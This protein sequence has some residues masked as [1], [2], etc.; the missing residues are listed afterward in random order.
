[1][2]RVGPAWGEWQE[3][4]WRRLK[5]ELP[6]ECGRLSVFARTEWRHDSMSKGLR[7]SQPWL[8][9]GSLLLG[10]SSNEMGSHLL[11]DA[12]NEPLQ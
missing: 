10:Q 9:A 11:D 6:T 7:S 3:K 4:G 8:Q 2:Q 12:W 5:Q 1:M